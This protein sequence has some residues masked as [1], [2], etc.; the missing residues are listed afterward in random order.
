M[1]IEIGA[2]IINTDHIVSMDRIAGTDGAAQWS[3]TLV[4]GKT[5]KV[6]ASLIDEGRICGTI[7]PAPPGLTLVEAF[8]PSPKEDDRRVHFSS[9]PVIAFRII[10]PTAAPEPIGGMGEPLTKGGYEYAVV[11]P[12]GPCFNWE[13]AWD[14][15]DAFKAEQ[16]ALCDEQRQQPTAANA[17][18]DRAQ[19]APPAIRGTSASPD[20]SAVGSRDD[21]GPKGISLFAGRSRSPSAVE[22]LRARILAE[23]IRPM[24]DKALWRDGQDFAEVI[25]AVRDANPDLHMAGVGHD[26]KWGWKWKPGDMER[27]RADMT[28]QG[29]VEEFERALRFLSYAGQR[30]GQAK[31]N[32]KRTSYAWKHVAERV[33]GAYVSNG[34]LVTAAHALGF[35][36][37]TND[38]PNPYINLGDKAAS[39]D[40]HGGL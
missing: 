18:T 20:A 24:S 36:V 16:Q 8:L 6:G 38:S 37:A 5:I 28:D 25:A 33:M 27:H 34:M 35:T 9:T 21:A 26:P 40:P 15:L 14:S 32:R 31:V 12:N 13:Q 17:V 23:P 7:V 39:L 30:F 29:H 1:L 2:T 4:T 11:Q 10:S 3:I 19:T 22:D